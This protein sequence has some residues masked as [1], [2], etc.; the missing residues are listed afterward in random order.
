MRIL[1][2]LA[3]TGLRTIRFMKEVGPSLISQI[4]ACDL[5]KSATDLMHSNFELN[6]LGDS[7]IRG[8]I[9]RQ[10]AKI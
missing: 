10:D 7:K 9:I 5:D 4:D 6:G 1:D 8:N 2:A 3:A